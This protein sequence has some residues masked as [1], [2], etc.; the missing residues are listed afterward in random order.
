[1]WSYGHG[2]TESPAPYLDVLAHLCMWPCIP[3]PRDSVHHIDRRVFQAA[4]LAGAV[5]FRRLFKTCQ[6]A[7]ATPVP[8]DLSRKLVVLSSFQVPSDDN[9]I[10]SGNMV[11][12]FVA[13]V[14][15]LLGTRGL[16]PKT[17]QNVTGNIS[18][19]RNLHVSEIS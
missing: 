18:Y 12:A 14:F 15:L 17:I 6:R 10:I 5:R 2:V 3:A 8:T 9:P 11:A 4:R 13:D 1:M 16:L 19:H 7:T